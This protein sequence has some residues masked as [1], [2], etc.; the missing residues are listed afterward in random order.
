MKED[1]N[2]VKTSDKIFVPVEKTKHIYKTEKRQC[3]TPITEN[4]TKTFKKSN[5]KKISNIN[6]TD[7]QITEKLSIDNRVQKLKELKAYVTVKDH[8]DKFGAK[9]CW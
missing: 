4:I 8:K 7:K 1:I 3:T 2:A 5:K 9:L 6:L